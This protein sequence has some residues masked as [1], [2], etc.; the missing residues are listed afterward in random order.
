[1]VMLDCENDTTTR[2]DLLME[3]SNILNTGLDRESLTILTKML[4]QGVHPEALAR[5]VLELD[6]ALLDVREKEK[7]AASRGG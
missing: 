4:E 1:M 5:V 7:K 2:E 3:I 6:R